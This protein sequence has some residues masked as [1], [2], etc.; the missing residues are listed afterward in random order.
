MRKLLEKQCTRK[1]DEEKVS[2]LL[3]HMALGVVWAESGLAFSSAR[4]FSFNLLFSQPRQQVH[5]P[6]GPRLSYSSKKDKAGN[7]TFALSLPHRMDLPMPA[8]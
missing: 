2:V 3:S 8:E 1:K 6:G 4:D 7:V 5:R